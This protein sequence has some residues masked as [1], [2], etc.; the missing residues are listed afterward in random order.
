MKIRFSTGDDPSFEDFADVN[1]IGTL[2][3]PN[4]NNMYKPWGGI[5]IHPTNVIRL[6]G[7]VSNTYSFSKSI[8]INKFTKVQLTLYQEE[9]VKGVGFCF[10]EFYSGGISDAPDF[11]CV[12]LRGGSITNLSSFVLAPRMSEDTEKD[13][14]GEPINIALN[15]RAQQSSTFGPGDAASA[16]DG[17]TKANF[18]YDAWERNSVTHSQREVNPWWEVILDKPHRIREVH[19]YKRVEDYEGDLSSL[20]IALFDT[21]DIEVERKELNIAPTGDS[22]VISFDGSLGYRLRIMLLGDFERILCLAEVKVFGFSYNF[23]LRIGKLLNF[24][25]MSINR[26][27]F[28]QELGKAG[29]T[30]PFLDLSEVRESTSIRD[31]Y[32]TDD[33]SQEVAVSFRRLLNIF[34]SSFMNN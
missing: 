8:A 16:I 18:D 22:L 26:V 32:I 14:Y 25:K 20:S 4:Q 13:L 21:H 5:N 29:L 1:R 3:L 6:Y 9:S 15:M 7:D 34:F 33:G 28:V 27:A 17:N 12:V 2:L 23:N 19:I 31:F 11:Y 30:H 10:Y 24:P